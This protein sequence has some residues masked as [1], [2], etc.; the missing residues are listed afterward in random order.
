MA[1]NP[2][3]VQLAFAAG[4]DESQREE[5]IDPTA[6]FTLLENVRQNQRGALEKR[7]AFLS[8]SAV[9]YTAGAIA[10]RSD[11][12]RLI[13]YGKAHLVIDGTY[14]DISDEGTYYSTNRVPEA[15]ATLLGVPTIGSDADYASTIHCATYCNGYL[16][17][18]WYNETPSAGQE[19]Y[20]AI[21]NAE[22]GAIVRGPEVFY[23]GNTQVIP[24]IVAVGTTLYAFKA[25]TAVANIAASYLDC[26]STAGIA[27]GWQSLGN[28]AVDHK[29]GLS[30]AAVDA[31]GL[32]DRA[33]FAYSN[34]SVG[35]SRLTVTAI[36]T[37]GFIHQTTVNTAS[38]DLSAVALGGSS[39]DTLWVAWCQSGAGTT[40]VIGLTPTSLSTI[41]ATASTIIATSGDISVAGSS[42]TTGAGRLFVTASGQLSMRSFTTSGGA[43][44]GSGS[45]IA[46]QNI[47]AF[48]TAFERSGRYYLVVKTGLNPSVVND[49]RTCIL[50]DATEDL[51]FLRPVANVIPGLAENRLGTIS[52]VSRGVSTDEW[53]FPVGMRLSQTSVGS[54][55]VK[56]DFAD[57]TRWQ[58]AF[59]GGS[60]YLSGGLTTVFDG[61]RVAEAGFLCRPRKPT[62]STSGTG[63]TFTTGVRYVAVYE[64]VDADGNWSVSGISD[65]S[66]ITGAVANKT[67]AVVTRPY[68]VSSRLSSTGKTSTNVMVTFYRTKD[69]GSAPYYRLASV[70]NDTASA[71][72]TYS[73][74]TTDATL[75]TAP[76]LYSP[77]L[78][79]T[80]GGALDRRAPP[81]LKH[82]VSYNGM[83]VGATGGDIFYSGQTVRGEAT[84]FSPVFQVPV[85]DEDEITA[86]AVQDGA[87]FVFTR[88]TVYAVSGDAPSDNGAVG[89]I[90]YPRRLA[91]DVGCISQRSV[92]VT[93]LGIFFQSDRGIELLTRAQ[94]VEWVGEGVQQT[95]ASYPYVSAATLDRVGSVVLFELTETEDSGAGTGD[96]RTLVYDL[97]LRTW[98]SVDRRKTATGLADY[99]AQHGAVI[100]STTEDAY[101]Y[102]W[103]GDNGIVYTETHT[104]N[105]DGSTQWI[106]MRAETGW[107]KLSGIQGRQI[108]NRFLLL[109]KQTSYADLSLQV[110]YDYSDTYQAAATWTA[111]TL[112]TLSTGLGRIQLQHDLHDD[113]EGQAVRLL[114]SDATPT[115]NAVGNGTGFTWIALTLEGAPRPLA[116]EVPD[117]AR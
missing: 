45:T 54:I 13:P 72:V 78:P 100:W 67:I 25:D 55:V 36:N 86:L 80:A 108:A 85:D 84:W 114:L 30:L 59:H 17:V 89:G 11:G 26:S 8:G 12:R 20:I 49:Q 87:L 106:T 112:A 22:T 70:T 44:T 104:S 113:A 43:T 31:I 74:T 42:T 51:T 88:T 58:P 48:S 16:G 39:S 4:I 111:P 61:K 71:T 65:P 66:D 68:T 52:A 19:F 75:A 77:S 92:V 63:L 35:T 103:V 107:F 102:A 10:S 27:S 9:R 46:V 64:E 50:A 2:Q 28:M 5:V 99:P 91:A 117:T 24:K 101:R 14:A 1:D 21:V 7:Y 33:V 97:N 62:T 69:G 57:R 79:G 98:I 82:L 76:K 6:G 116:A 110:A 60:L 96:G 109:G 38:T 18:G 105:L 34:T 73:D 29:T 56:F 95:L 32:S 53:H 40:R 37:S 83:L 81:G 94:S 23:T 115:T 41:K 3:L 90:S 47:D 15:T 93:S